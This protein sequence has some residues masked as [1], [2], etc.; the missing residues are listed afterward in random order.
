M[1]H[2]FLV[3]KINMRFEKMYPETVKELVN[4]IVRLLSITFEWLEKS[5]EL[6]DDWK[7]ANVT[8]IFKDKK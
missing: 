6:P 7:K 5:G 2:T 3:L 4:I 1:K 8:L